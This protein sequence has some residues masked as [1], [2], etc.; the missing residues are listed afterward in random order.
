M[1]AEIKILN[2][3]FKIIFCQVIINSSFF[4]SIL[5]PEFKKN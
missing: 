1:F 5:M 3:T 4:G 2:I